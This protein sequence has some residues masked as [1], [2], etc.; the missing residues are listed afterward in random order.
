[1]AR[2]KESNPTAATLRDLEASGDRIAE[3]ASNN[4]ALILG[5]IAGV[6]VIAAGV[7]IWSQHSTSQRE[8]AVNALAEVSSGY[9]KAMGAD[10]L[11]A[12][13]SEP[14]NAELAERTR[15]EYVERFEMVGRE[16]A[17]TTVAAVALL[18]AAKLHVELGAEDAG[19]ANYEAARDA[20]AKSAIAALASVRLAGLAEG[21][22]DM[23]AAAQAF[24]RAASIAA[25]PLRA[26]ALGD[27]ARCWAQANDSDRA[28]A[29]YQRFQAEFPDARIAPY[30]EALMNELK[31][32]QEA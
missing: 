14:A 24:E 27:A 15:R 23:K 8:Q 3:W 6:L 12:E 13:I 25:Y 1:M 10:P 28:L 29:A 21:R 2:K 9:R 4:A 11:A 7:G 19:I 20:A 31:A 17:G 5:A 30:I 26:A 32:K 16:Y 22:G 18:E